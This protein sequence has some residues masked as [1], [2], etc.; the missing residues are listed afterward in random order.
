MNK[1]TGKNKKELKDQESGQQDRYKS[2]H[3]SVE[4]MSA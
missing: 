3:G 1:G 4:V 2:F